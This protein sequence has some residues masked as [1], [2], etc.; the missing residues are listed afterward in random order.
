MKDKFVEMVAHLAKPGEDL[1]KEW[2]ANKASLVHMLVGMYDEA[3]EVLCHDSRENLIEEAGDFIFYLQ[4]AANDLNITLDL[5]ERDTPQKID[6]VSFFD[7]VY[8]LLTQLKRHLFY[9]KP[10]PEKSAL[11][12]MFNKALDSVYCYVGHTLKVHNSP[13]VSLEYILSENYT[14]LMLKRYPN[15]F[16]ND[17]ANQRLDKQDANEVLR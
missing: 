10:L 16:S 2:N 1:M 13:A 4:G 6:Y 17:A 12:E 9:N 8:E 14:K 7:N 11:E 5:S 15:G 3:Q